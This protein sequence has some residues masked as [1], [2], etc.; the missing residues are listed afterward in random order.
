MNSFYFKKLTVSGGGHKSSTIDFCPGFNLIIGPS[1]TGKSFVMDCLDYAL[2]AMPSKRRPSKV[3]DANNGYETITLEL[4]TSNGIVSLTRKIGAN[5]IDV[6]SDNPTVKT[7]KY[8]V[9]AASKNNINSV[10]LSLLGI[11]S[12]HMV[13]SSESGKTQKLTWRSMLHLFFIR[14]PDVARESSPFTIPGW[15]ATTASMSTLLFLLTGKDANNSEEAE[16]PAIRKAKKKALITYIRSKLDALGA[17]RSDLENLTEKY[18]D[19]DILKSIEDLKGKMRDIHI[20]I[21]NASAKGQTIISKIYELNGKLSECETVI[22]SFSILHQQYESDIQRLEFIINGGLVAKQLPHDEV[23]PFCNSKITTSPDTKYINASAAE[24]KR[25]RLHLEELFTAKNSVEKKKQAILANI[26]SLESQKDEVDSLVSKDL[27]PQLSSFQK[28]LMDKMKLVEIASELNTLKQY[29]SQYR[30]ELFDKETEEEPTAVKHKIAAGFDYDLIDGFEQ[31][32]RTILKASKIGGSSTAHLNMKSFDIEINGISKIAL[33]GG[34]FCALFNTIAAYTMSEY[35]IEK[36]G[37]AP[38]FFAVDSSLTQLSEPEKKIKPNAIKNNFVQ[39]L[40]NNA[41]KRQV[42][43]IEQKRRMPFIP[44]E[45]PDK[46]VH[47]IEFTGDKHE[48]RYGFLNDV[49]NIDTL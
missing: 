12:D 8:S 35:I 27:I 41:L 15:F 48:G 1:N 30:K 42:I 24:L 14:Q 22:H 46:G 21:E 32:L 18:K 43:M 6:K 36:G 47:V 28:E 20:Q 3:I 26:K 4:Q 45:A 37:Y 7:Q 44:T 25:I 31:K 11:T 17:K 2:G 38:H 5:K 39:Y 19:V 29:E 40:I 16:D 23:C 13:L 34:G 33:M 49:Y 10:F 9:S